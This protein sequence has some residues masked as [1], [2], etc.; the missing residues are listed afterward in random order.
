MTMPMDGER[1]LTRVDFGRLRRLLA[2]S[3]APALE[4]LL[5]EAE[6]VDSREM[7][8]DVVTMYAQFEIEEGAT[9]R[10]QSLVICYPGDADPAAGY[11]SVLS[12]VGLALLGLR[13]G[14]VA[15]W[16]TP[17]GEAHSAEL[18]AVKFQPEATGDYVT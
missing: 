17:G 8:A 18:L 9:G 7:P 14:D 6:V 15:R 10:R 16:Q 3:P 5:A 1:K 11:I 4:D 12:P 2:A 13:V